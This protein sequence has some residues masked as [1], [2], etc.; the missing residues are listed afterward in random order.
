[1]PWLFTPLWG[2]LDFVLAQSEEDACRFKKL[3]IAEESVRDMGNMKF[4]QAE[5][6][7]VEAADAGGLRQAWGYAR[8]ILC[9]SLAVR[10]RGKKRRLWTLSRCCGRNFRSLS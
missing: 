10:I 1:V 3:G 4:D 7:D 9:G 6:S 8:T 2:K 5:W